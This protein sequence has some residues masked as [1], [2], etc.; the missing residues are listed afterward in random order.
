MDIEFQLKN[1]K[2]YYFNIEHKKYFNDEFHPNKE[3]F[4]SDGFDYSCNEC[5]TFTDSNVI[6]KLRYNI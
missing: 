4:Q 6:R 5:N 2:E 1:E 3:L